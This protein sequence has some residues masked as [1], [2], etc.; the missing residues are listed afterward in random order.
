MFAPLFLTFSLFA[1]QADS[2]QTG[3][4]ALDRQDYAQAEQIFSKLTQSDPKDYAAFFYLANI[5]A[6]F[7]RAKHFV[8]LFVERLVWEPVVCK[9]ASEDRQD[10]EENPERLFH[11][12]KGHPTFVPGRGAVPRRYR[13]A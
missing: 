7:M 4:Q 9:Q 8:L 13:R 10:N 5:V 12:P 11:M 2:Q 6:D 1:P 3:L